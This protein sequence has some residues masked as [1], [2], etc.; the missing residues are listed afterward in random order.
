MP[1]I[2]LLDMVC[3]ISQSRS[4]ILVLLDEHINTKDVGGLNVLHA[5]RYCIVLVFVEIAKNYQNV[6]FK[7]LRSPQLCHA[8]ETSSRFF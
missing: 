4:A 3:L 5:V 8:F 1:R 7:R 2:D 6:K